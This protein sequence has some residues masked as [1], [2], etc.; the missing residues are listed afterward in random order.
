[1][2]D[3]LFGRESRK[4]PT[5]ETK[6]FRGSRYTF[7]VQGSPEDEYFGMLPAHDLGGLANY[8][9]RLAK[10]KHVRNCLDIGANIGLSS[11]LMTEIVPTAKIFSFEPS[12][13]TYEHL[14][15]N[16]NRNMGQAQI[17]PQPMAVGDRSG[18]IRFAANN[19]QSH[20]NHISL[21]GQGIEVEMQSV[22]EFVSSAGLDGVDFIKADV[23][24]FE[25][26]VFQGAVNTL[27]RFR[28]A[29]LFEFNEYAIVYNAHADP[30]DYLAK[31]MSVLGA[32]AIVDTLTGES[33]PLPYEPTK[34]IEVLRAK[35]DSDFAIFDLTNQAV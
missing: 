12:P 33:T 26:P 9:T 22:D 4:M 17:S 18:T 8:F 3:R 1:M 24:G 31:L 32:L 5:M 25:L 10:V 29:V 21:D 19:V 30:I 14:V 2:L 11:L 16:I 20:A 7:D 6:Q 34:A 15:A 23:E 13:P 35:K 28:P 27:L